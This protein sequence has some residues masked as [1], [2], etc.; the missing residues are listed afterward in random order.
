M[1]AIIGVI[2]A[3]LI[4]GGGAVALVKHN[5]NKP[6]A[7]PASSATSTPKK[8]TTAASNTSSSAEST[9]PASTAATVSISNFAF[10]PSSLTVKKGATVTW[11]NKDS[12]GHNVKETDGQDGPKSGD[13]N[14]GQ[15]YSFT[16][17]TVGTFKYN[18]S[19]HPNMTGT[20][21]VTE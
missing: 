14:Q 6:A 8:A 18:C 21:I 5:D 12:I 7:K 10:S 16:F 9:A 19:I 4:I 15:S 11:T 20:V 1:K 13:L 2:L 17:N 3:I